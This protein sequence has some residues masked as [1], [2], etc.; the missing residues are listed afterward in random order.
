M[1]FQ[2]LAGSGISYKP[3]DFKTEVHFFGQIVGASNVI[4]HDS[5]FIEAYF[6]TGEQWRYLSP[7]LFIQTQTCEVDH[8]NNVTFC[9]P[10]DLH[11][12]TENLSGWPRLVVR[13]WKL[14]DT[15][16]VNILSYGTCYLPNTKGYHE[17]EF[18]T[19]CLK[20]SVADEAL[21]CQ[22]N[23]KPLI[24]MSD[25]MDPNLIK[26]NFLLS[27]PGPKVKVTCEVILRNFTFHA[28]SGLEEEKVEEEENVYEV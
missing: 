7:K 13:I 1:I 28:L 27:K 22:L 14:G 25:P 10:F 5:V 16:K 17:L 2:K 11:L 23:S 21:W 19:F 6:V 15:N 26:R 3:A 20:F 18:Q 9:H 4:E 12:T 24:S 8:F